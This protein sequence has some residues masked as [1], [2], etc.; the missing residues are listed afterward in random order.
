MPG[1]AVWL[2]LPHQLDLAWKTP[3][4]WR[5]CVWRLRV[6]ASARGKG[7]QGLGQRRLSASVSAHASWPRPQEEMFEMDW[8]E[9]VRRD[10]EGSDSDTR[11]RAASEL[12]K[13]LT[14]RFP[15][16]VGAGGRGGRVHVHSSVLPGALDQ[17]WTRRCQHGHTRRQDGGWQRTVLLDSVQSA[18]LLPAPPPP[19]PPST[20]HHPHPIPPP[21][22]PHH[23][24][25][26]P[27]TPARPA[28]SPSCSAGTWAPCWRS[29]PPPPPAAG[30][31]RTARC[32]W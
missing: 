12:V 11:R 31:P 17:R 10:T 26:Q 22:L 30:R 2:V 18:T 13:S 16:Q 28:R 27:P 19:A 7:Q 29:T 20:I 24:H 3:K 1:T 4:G 5:W 15:Q 8:V 6:K 9:Y 14:D 32:T 25:H 21:H 23:H